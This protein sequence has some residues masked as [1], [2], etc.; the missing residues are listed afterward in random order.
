[1]AVGEIEEQVVIAGEGGRLFGMMHCPAPGSVRG[2]F[3]ICHPFA[4]E[5]KCA[6]RAL[7]MLARAMAAEGFAALRFDLTG[8]GDS[9][10]THGD[11]TVSVW[12]RDI[13]AAVGFL[14]ERA[15]GVPV[16]AMG[17]RLGATLAAAAAADLPH[18]KRLILWEPVLSGE[19]YFATS[20]RR[21]LIKQMMTD[22]RSRNTR[23]EFLQRLRRGEGTVDYD[24]FEV[25]GAL[26]QELCGLRLPAAPPADDVFML[27][28][29]V[30]AEIGRELEA[31][32]ASWAEQGAEQGASVA[33]EAITSPPI[34]SRLELVDAGPM[35][36]ATMRRL[37]GGV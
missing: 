13:A 9:E 12:R 28:I 21:I 19:D 20:L 8:C 11:A 6:H 23:D 3:A 32:S 26:Y 33:V 2:A 16:G 1:M 4:E 30:R 25:T 31:L 18:L 35:I 15:P 36:E 5:K 14:G 10:G 34:W 37:R 29:G 7:V 27:Q 24:G 22:G 17:V